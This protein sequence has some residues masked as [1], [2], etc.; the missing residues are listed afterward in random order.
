MLL[1]A[2]DSEYAVIGTGGLAASASKV[3]AAMLY[4][5]ENEA[6]VLCQMLDTY[7]SL[8]LENVPFL[9]HATWSCKCFCSTIK[10]VKRP[11]M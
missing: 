8:F 1:K 5:H 9:R 3:S 11:R 6:K 10:L 7:I 2:K 4:L